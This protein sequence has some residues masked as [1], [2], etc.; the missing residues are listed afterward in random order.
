MTKTEYY[1][2][3]DEILPGLEADVKE[4]LWTMVK[5]LEEENRLFEMHLN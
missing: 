1:K 5:V 2:E 3:L 4:N